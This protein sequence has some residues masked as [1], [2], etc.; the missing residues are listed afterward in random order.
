M[1]IKFISVT[2]R[3]FLSFGNSPVTIMLDKPGSTLIRG[4]NYESSADGAASN[5]AGKTTVLQA[6]VYALY[7]KPIS[8]INKDNLVNLINGKHMEVS[9]VFRR[10][11]TYYKVIRARKMKAGPSGN[12]T[13]LFRREHDADFTDEDEITFDS[14]SNT[15][16]EIVKVVG[17]PYELFIRMIVYSGSSVPFLSLPLKHVSQPSQQSFIEELFDLTLLTRKADTLKDTLKKDEADL[18]ALEMQRRMFDSECSK[19]KERVREARIKLQEWEATQNR[20]IDGWRHEIAQ[21]ESIN[22]DEQKQVFEALAEIE[23]S[24]PTLKE[25]VSTLTTKKRKLEDTCDQL[26]HELTHLTSDTCPYC[27]QS[28]TNADKIDALTED[29][30]RNEETLTTLSDE[31]ERAKSVL[32]E[33]GDAHSALR[34]AAAV[35]SIEQ[36]YTVN[37]RRAELVARIEEAQQRANPYTEVVEMLESQQPEPFDVETL[38]QLV[39]DVEHKKFLVKLLT[40]NDSFI[41]KALVMKN[42]PFLNG[43]LNY[44]LRRM[45]LPHVVEFTHDLTP[46]ITRLG[47]EFDFDNLSTGQKARVNIALALSFRDVLQNLHQKVNLFCIDEA[48]DLGLD[49][50]GVLSVAKILKEEARKTGTCLFVISHRE[51]LM[52]TF[53]K[54]LLVTLKDGFS[55]ILEVTDGETEE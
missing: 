29:L 24:L 27:K 25:E 55:K 16:D 30:V 49:A 41:R 34:Q 54:K 2:L 14:S 43:R 11:D 46:K 53:D 44:Y 18:A 38:N 52:A 28:Y 4:K 50:P 21:I 19:H 42:L 8:N 32:S 39:E 37:A 15:T 12:W 17:M 10:N 47:S 22:I 40:K 13:K 3:N 26:K 35:S 5:G 51:E 33:Q 6:I 9:L 36:L 20:Q 7:D 48:L 31:L 1:S 45:E 23:R